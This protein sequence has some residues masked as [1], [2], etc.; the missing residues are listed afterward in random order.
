[1]TISIEQLNEEKQLLQADFDKM[2]SQINKITNDLAQMKANLNAIN[3]AVQQ[4]NKLIEM[5][6]EKKKK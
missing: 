4:V 2:N 5:S 3:G 6:A 1:M